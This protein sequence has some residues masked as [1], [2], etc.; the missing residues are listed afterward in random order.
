MLFNSPEFVILLTVTFILYYI[1]FLRK[2]QTYTLII[3]SFAFY[4]YTLPLL[5]LLLIASI[6]INV[7]TS[8]YIYHNKDLK[9]KRKIAIVGV[10]LNLLTLAFFKYSPLF[11]Q[12]FNIDTTNFGEFLIAI[13]LPIGISFFTFQGIS[14]LVDTFSDNYKFKQNKEIPDKLITHA[15]RTS[16]FI[17]F[18]PQL[19]AGPIVKAHEFFY[20]IKPK[21]IKKINWV[22]IFK[23]IV[24]GYFLKMVVA[25]NL[26]DFTFELTYPYFLRFS[27]FDLLTMLFGYS[28]QIFAD[29]AGYS[30]IAIGVSGLFGYKIP[31][32]FNFP[33]IAKSFSEFWSRWHISLSSFLKEYL[34]FPL[35]GNRRGRYRTYFNLFIVMV[36]GGLW[37]GAAWSYA[38]WGLFH[39]VLLAIERLFKDYI[40]IPENIIFKILQTILVFTMVT[41][42]WLLFKLPD[43]THV[44][45]YFEALF[46]NTDKSTSFLFNRYIWLYSIP[47]I[48]FHIYYLYTEKVKNTKLKKYEFIVY[49]IMLFLIV[50]NSGSPNAFIYFQF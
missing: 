29:F 19:V 8:Y 7:I 25:D 9:N 2:I 41:F 33:Y 45:A 1:P 42:A 12:T 21:F 20:Q 37:H 38:I 17:S 39:G 35:G 46:I 18:F 24:L 10:F 13:P 26:K 27:T 32:N 5:L 34:Y 43:F 44:I 49:G 15:V 23:L 22:E 50:T 14:L 47:V 3:A 4:A 31:Q 28:M 36:L 16:L 11:A 6:S 48:I 40:K 30:L